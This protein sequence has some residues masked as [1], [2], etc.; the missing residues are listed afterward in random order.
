MKRQGN[1]QIKTDPIKTD[2]ESDIKENRVSWIY[3]EHTVREVKAT[4][5]YFFGPHGFLKEPENLLNIVIP[6]GLQIVQEEEVPFQLPQHQK[7]TKT[8]QNLPKTALFWPAS[9]LQIF[10]DHRLLNS[11]GQKI[12]MILPPLPHPP[13]FRSA[14]EVVWMFSESYSS[15]YLPLIFL[16]FSS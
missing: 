16:P 13:Y 12:L 7:G 4:I 11:I 8:H 5:H 3:S 1:D 2:A 15:S 10:L 6:L 14:W 9:G